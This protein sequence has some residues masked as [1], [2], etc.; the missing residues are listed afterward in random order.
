M[1]EEDSE[2][3]ILPAEGMSEWAR[4]VFMTENSPLYD[5]VHDP[6]ADAFVGFLWANQPFEQR[7][8]RRWADAGLGAPSGDPWTKLAH[9]VQ[10]R[11]WFGGIPDFIIRIDAVISDGLSDRAFCALI[12][13]ELRHCIQKHDRNGAPVFS[14]LTGDPIWAIRPHDIEEF[15]EIARR[16]GSWEDARQEYELALIEGPTISLTD[17]GAACG[18]DLKVAS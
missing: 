11:H 8:M 4:I 7:G 18:V 6:I 9:Q 5:S 3:L 12:D 17:I 14:K 10:L 2:P 16:Y 13:H 1:L 15:S